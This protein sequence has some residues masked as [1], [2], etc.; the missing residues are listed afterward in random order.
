MQLSLE[1]KHALVCGGSKGIGFASAQQLAMLGAS[2]TLLSRDVMALAHADTL[3][4]ISQ[5]QHHGYLS[6]DLSDPDSVS[7]IILDWVKHKPVHILVNNAGG[8][9]SGP[10]TDA[11]MHE[12]AAAFATHVLSSHVIT[13]A[14][15]PGM[16]AAGYGRIINVISTSVKQPIPGLG[17]SNTI[18]GAMGNWSKTLAGE[19]GKDGIT[20]NNVLP[21][22][23]GTDRLQELFKSMAQR[24]NTTPEEYAVSIRKTIPLGRFAD[25]EEIGQVVAFLASPAASYITGTNVVVDGG[26]TGCL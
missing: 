3:L 21:G 26:R 6:A 7:E 1:G 11:G 12:F 10:L 23:T 18:R 5:G 2:V 25:P 15:L 13:R 19:V 24:L 17:V 16:R 22:M 20:V 8:P 9:K 14:V 4:D